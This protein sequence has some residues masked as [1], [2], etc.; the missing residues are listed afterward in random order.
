ME[1]FKLFS[2]EHVNN[3]RQPAFDLCKTIKHLSTE[4]P[5][6]YIASWIIIG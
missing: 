2:Q 1:I 4:L 3:V 6:P 5:T